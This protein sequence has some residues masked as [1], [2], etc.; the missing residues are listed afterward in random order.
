LEPSDSYFLFADFVDFCKKEVTCST[1]PNITIRLQKVQKANN[2]LS[3]YM[4]SRP[5]K[6]GFETKYHEKVG[7]YSVK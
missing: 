7:I 3:E 5:H 6:T 4:T 2:K 1:V